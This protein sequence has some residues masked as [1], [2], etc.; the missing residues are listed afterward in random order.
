MVDETLEGTDRNI[1][2]SMAGSPSNKLTKRL[3]IK[4]GSEAFMIIGAV[5][6][7]NIESA[8]D[9]ALQP[10]FIEQN[11]EFATSGELIRL[12]LEKG[13]VAFAHEL[14]DAGYSLPA[15]ILIKAIKKNKPEAIRNIITGRF[16]PEVGFELEYWYLLY[17]N[18]FSFA[19]TMRIAEPQLQNYQVDEHNFEQDNEILEI[20]LKRSL[21]RGYDDFAC[22]I[23]KINPMVVNAEMIQIALNQKNI[24][25]LRRIWTGSQQD[26]HAF[27]RVKRLQTSALWTNLNTKT[28]DQT[29]A[30]VSDIMKISYII[31]SLLVREH[32][33]E[34]RKVIT[35]PEAADDKDILRVCVEMGEEEIGR[36]VIS[37]RTRDV[38]QEDF[39]YCISEK[40][41]WLALDMLKWDE[42]LRYLYNKDAQKDIVE[43]LRNGSTCYFAAE[44]LARIKPAIWNSA[45][46]ETVCEIVGLTLKKSI[47]FYKCPHPIMYL[48]LMAEF[49]L[50]ISGINIYHSTICKETAENLICLAKC[51]EDNIDEE[52]EL[53]YFLMSKDTQGRTV[54]TIIAINDFFIL[55]ENNDVGSIINNMWIGD[56]KNEGILKASTLFTSF[57]APPGSEEKLSF[58]KKMDGRKA[59]M[60]QYEQLVSSCKLRFFGQMISVALLVYF[61]S[62]M[63]ELAHE[64]NTLENFA[65]G[66][67]TQVF[68]RLS[69]IWIVGIFLEK[70]ITMIFFSVTK[71]KIIT[72]TWLILDLFMF[73]MMIFLMAGINQYYAGDGKWLN[74]ISSSDFNALMHA[75]VLCFVWLKLFS[76]LVVTESYGPLLRIMYI[77]T[78]DMMTFLLVYFSAL[79]IGAVIMATLFSG[80]TSSSKFENFASSFLSLYRIG[81]GDFT[82]TDYTR[83]FAFGAVL[84]GILVVLTN[85]MLFNVLIAILT[86]TYEREVEGEESKYRATLIK[87]YYRWRWDDDYGL[88]I[89]M[90]SPITI[91]ITA[92]LPLLLGVKNSSRI[93]KLFSRIFFILFV[94]PMFIYFAIMS[95]LFIPLVYLNSLEAFA[96]GGIKTL[97]PRI[98][99]TEQAGPGETESDE[100]EEEDEDL[101]YSSTGKEIPRLKTF[102]IRRA[103]IWV[104]VGGVVTALAYLRDLLDFWRLTF[105]D[106]RKNTFNEEEEEANI[107]SNEIFINNLQTTLSSFDEDEVTVDEVVEKYVSVDNALLSSIVLADKNL[108]EKRMQSVVG[109]FENMSYSK[110][111]RKIRRKDVLEMLPHKNYYSENFI[112]RARHIRIVWISKALKTFRKTIANINVK[113]VDLPKC[114]ILNETFQIRRV[115]MTAKTVKYSLNDAEKNLKVLEEKLNE[116]EEIDRIMNNDKSQDL[117]NI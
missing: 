78:I 115:M 9:I 79:F 86:V 8:R 2:R 49:L 5:E 4:F 113:G 44:M 40:F 38:T 47:E 76:I 16:Y 50:K 17:K 84:E 56:R 100:E 61:Y 66:E 74:F 3:S 70:V 57:F 69:Q 110:K 95:S 111:W 55:L 1:K 53:K 62:M 7:C 32:I 31:K 20:A 11:N 81:L 37:K 52:N 28:D 98:I 85:V 30:E 58:F 73:L 99:L 105:K 65:N 82:I 104:L 59:Y 12:C 15:D 22:I 71:R 29:K 35:W 46:T 39:R 14:I 51:I 107:L 25:F 88:L 54:L 45:N 75:V 116:E 67:K 80:C 6:L 87:A 24:D 94:L 96:K 48:V 91:F 83:Y 102:S 101:E 77:M 19:E 42:P 63:V 92:V 41:Y 93:T 33:Q 109:F 21:E 112:F 43:L 13:F 23:M 18:M 108:M 103:V 90:P 34:A 68:L 64:E 117:M 72:D 106:S 26:N 36:D 10:W 97:E 27:N 114:V 60:F 89:L